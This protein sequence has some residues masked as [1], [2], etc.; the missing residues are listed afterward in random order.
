MS[1]YLIGKARNQSHVALVEAIIRGH[2]FC[3]CYRAH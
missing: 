2:A 1:L 3:Y